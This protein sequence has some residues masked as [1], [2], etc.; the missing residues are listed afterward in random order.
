L[1]ALVVA[2]VA[3]LGTTACS[4]SGDS[5]A[6]EARDDDQIVVGSF[7]FA[8]SKLL[9]ALYGNALARHGYDVGFRLGIGPREIVDPALHQGLVDVVPEYAGT[10][11]QFLGVSDR[12]SPTDDAEAHARLRAAARRIGVV[13]LAPSPAQDANAFVVRRSTA[14]RHRLRDLSDLARVAPDLVFGGPPECPERPLCLVGLQDVYGIEFGNVVALDVGGPLTVQSLETGDI[15]VGLLFTSDP[16]LREAGFVALRDDRRLQPAENVTPLVRTE[17]EPRF[18]PD[19]VDALDAVSSR[20]T[21][22][23]LRRLNAQVAADPDD[24]HVIATRWVDAKV[25]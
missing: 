5:D 14:R 16:V 24:L 9:A 11:A 21:T 3:A 23:E 4:G 1:L 2:L 22:I 10:A 7:D 25:G 15:D 17:F 8:E 19:A 13:A 6:D 12:V 20:L 18:G